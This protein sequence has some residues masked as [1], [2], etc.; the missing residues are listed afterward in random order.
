MPKDPMTHSTRF[1]RLLPWFLLL[2]LLI[3]LLYRFRKKFLLKVT[4]RG[5]TDTQ[6]R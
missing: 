6:T 1:Y 4:R 3:C 2:C 5:K